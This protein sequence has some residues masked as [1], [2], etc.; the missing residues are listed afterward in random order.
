MCEASGRFP[1]G[2]GA[3]L[4]GSKGPSR[5]PSSASELASLVAPPLISAGGSDDPLYI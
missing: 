3:P 5:V 2:Y 1:H 4:T